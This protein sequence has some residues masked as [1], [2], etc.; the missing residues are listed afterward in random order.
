MQS[1]ALPTYLTWERNSVLA[2]SIGQLSV[3]D[4]R[5]IFLSLRTVSSSE[6]TRIF[7]PKHGFTLSEFAVWHVIG[8]R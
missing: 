6:Q 7:F 2:H 8:Q 1:R 3:R 4:K 5:H